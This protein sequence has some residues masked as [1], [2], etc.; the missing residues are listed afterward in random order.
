VIP[1]LEFTDL[2]E[3]ILPTLTELSEYQIVEKRAQPSRG[4]IN[5]YIDQV[6]L[7]R[8]EN[9]HR[10]LTDLLASKIRMKGSLPRF[11]QLIDLAA[12]FNNTNYIFE[13]KSITETNVRTQIRKGIS[14]LY[15]YRYL[16]NLSNAKL[17]LVIEKELPQMLAGCSII[18]SQIGKLC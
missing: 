10:K 18:L 5:Y 9:A 7:E 1:T 12:K 6:K 16:Q 2:D 3:P 8:A 17:V 4:I 14:Q 13:I 15:E 11:N